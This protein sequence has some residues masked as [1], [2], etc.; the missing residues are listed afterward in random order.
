VTTIERRTL[1]A[2]PRARVFDLARSIDLHVAST[3][4][5]HERAV[6]GVTS[7]LI[8]G[9][10]EVTWEARHFGVMQRFSSRI[11]AFDPP[12]HFQDTMVRG[13]FSQFVHD[14]LFDE[15]GDGQT[16][17]SDRLVFA[18][19]LGLLGRIVDRLL[20]A[21]YLGRFLDARNAVIKRVAESDTDWKQY[22]S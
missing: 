7:G 4:G 20:L 5:T 14:H 21:S 12:R 1:I 18:A 15:A 8:A 22:L 11:T 6:A 17:M 16:T 10:Q 13:A 2:A 3:D 19:P 9:G